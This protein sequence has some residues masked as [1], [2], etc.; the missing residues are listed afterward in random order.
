[1]KDIISVLESRGGKKEAQ[2]AD[3]IL[4]KVSSDRAE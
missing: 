1:M 2:S 4:G 3:K